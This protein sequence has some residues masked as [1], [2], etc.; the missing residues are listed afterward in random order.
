MMPKYRLGDNNRIAF[1]ATSH[2]LA[3]YPMRQLMTVA[4]SKTPHSLAAAERCIRRTWT[5]AC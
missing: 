3:Y 1:A 5:D 2:L 4:V